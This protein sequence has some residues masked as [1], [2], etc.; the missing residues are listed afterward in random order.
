[1]KPVSDSSISYFHKMIINQDQLKFFS[2]TVDIS[3][4]NL[5]IITNKEEKSTAQRLLCVINKEWCNEQDVNRVPTFVSEGVPSGI[6]IGCLD[7][8]SQQWNKS[9][10]L[11]MYE[12]GN[13]IDS[14]DYQRLS[15]QLQT[16][17]TLSIILFLFE[18]RA[19]DGVDKV[20]N[21]LD[22]ILSQTFYI[23]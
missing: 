6:T 7:E 8:L 18:S 14:F 1:M 9:V 20:S 22:I 4:N 13:N 12:N 3:Q 19:M 2:H 23:L 21:S 15:L 17:W 10:T 11:W 16:F 5:F